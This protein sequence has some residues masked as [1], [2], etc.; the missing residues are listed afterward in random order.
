[1]DT[2]GL[3]SGSSTPTKPGSL[4][5]ATPLPLKLED[6]AKLVDTSSQVSVP[7]DAEMD[8]PTLVEIHASLPPKMKLQGLAWK[9]P[10]RCGLTIKGG[11]QGIGSPVGDQVFH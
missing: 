3:A 9:P 1:M 2:S 11:Q 8:D 5:L 6:S 4:P 10:F 7:E